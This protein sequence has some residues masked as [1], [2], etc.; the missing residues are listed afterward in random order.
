M[1]QSGFVIQVTHVVG[2]Y[3]LCTRVL[4]FYHV[5]INDDDDDDDINTA[6]T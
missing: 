2:L 6:I 1:S 3:V 4:K 5:R